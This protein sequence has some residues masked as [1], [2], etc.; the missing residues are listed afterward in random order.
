MTNYNVRTCLW[1]DSQGLEAAEFYITLLPESKIDSVHWV[2]G[3]DGQ[4]VPMI[5]EYTLNGAPYMHLTA[6]PMFPQSECASISVT[7]PTQAE[8][9]RLWTALTAHGGQES[10]CGWLKDRWGVSWQ[11]VPA[12]LGALLSGPKAAQI[13]PLF[14]TM[15]RID[16]AALEAAAEA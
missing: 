13:M 2:P 7:T 4:K 12:G 5:V 15:N 9:D 11:I 14:Q 10:R 8:T 6:G 16:M 1:F 3:P